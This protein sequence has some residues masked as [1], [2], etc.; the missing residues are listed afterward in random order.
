LDYKVAEDN[1]RQDQ[2]LIIKFNEFIRI[3]RGIQKSDKIL[4]FY[5]QGSSIYVRMKRKPFVFVKFFINEKMHMM[6]FIV[7]QAKRGN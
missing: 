4:L 6:L 1:E 3:T 5:Y 7:Y 2:E